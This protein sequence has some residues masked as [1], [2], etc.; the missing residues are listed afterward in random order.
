M[1]RLGLL[2]VGV[3]GVAVIAIV[4]VVASSSSDSSDGDAVDEAMEVLPADAESILFTD[5]AGARERLGYGDL[6]SESSQSQFESYIKDS[7]ESPW[8]LS[9]L[10]QYF[11]VMDEWGWSFVDVEWEALLMGEDSNATAL[12]FHDDLDM[13]VVEASF[14]DKGY[15]RSDVQGFPAYA[16]NLS[17]TDSA[18]VIAPLL[19][20]VVLPDQHLLLTGPDAESLIDTVT[21]DADPLADS[22]VASDLVASLDAPE[23]LTLSAGESSCVDPAEALGES[24]TPEAQEALASD[25]ADLRDPE[26]HVA[27]ITIGDDGPVARVVVGYGDSETAEADAESR[28]EL[29]D[30][31]A[32]IAT[33]E[34]YAELLGAEV[35]SD[36]DLIRYELTTDKAR[37]SL[38]QMVQRRDVPWAFCSA[39]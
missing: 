35:D 9:T 29:L 30:N 7:M 1:E 18:E 15:E 34:P 8:A 25:L 10:G 19:N 3:L 26:G 16:L 38:S 14:E 17:E 36:G 4:T 12:K 33:G 5:L 32:S 28:Q 2:V 20:V 39:G 24:G 13:G 11:Q 23:F 6:T 21:G 27:A 22:D 31:G 37:L